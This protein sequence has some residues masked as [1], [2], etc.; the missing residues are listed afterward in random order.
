MASLT[1]NN[2]TPKGGHCFSITLTLS[3]KLWQPSICEFG[4]WF[5]WFSHINDNYVM[6]TNWPLKATL[7]GHWLW[8]SSHLRDIKCE[9]NFSLPRLPFPFSWVSFGFKRLRWPHGFGFYCTALS[10]LVFGG[11]QG[12][13]GSQLVCFLALTC[14]RGS[15]GALGLTSA[16]AV[17]LTSGCGFGAS[18]LWLSNRGPC[19][20]SP[21]EL[22]HQPSSLSL[23]S[24]QGPC[25]V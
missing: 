17:L 3:S 10:C 9:E 4:S 13:Q 6:T 20:P 11:G 12:N 1:C 14:A 19:T 15:W 5:F 25:F 18:S 16:L 21:S 7:R 2:F 8:L 22:S 24:Q 23:E